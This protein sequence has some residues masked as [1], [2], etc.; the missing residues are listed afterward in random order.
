MASAR[1]FITAASIS[2]SKLVDDGE[3]AVVSV[4]DDGDGEV[5]G[6]GETIQPNRIQSLRERARGNLIFIL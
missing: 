5:I 3:E 2:A 1:D 4:L 6:A